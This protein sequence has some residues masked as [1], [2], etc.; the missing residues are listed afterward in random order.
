MALVGVPASK[1]EA[2]PDPLDDAPELPEPAPED[3][4]PELVPELEPD[5]ELEPEPEELDDDPA[6]ASSPVPAL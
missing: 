5:P 1:A 6:A 3:P 2:S 4:E